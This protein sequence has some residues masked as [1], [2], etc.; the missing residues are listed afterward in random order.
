LSFDLAARSRDATEFTE[1]CY[2]EWIDW[3]FARP[4]SKIKPVP[5]DKPRRA[6]YYS[7]SSLE[8]IPV[9]LALI[10]F[11]KSNSN[12]SIIAGANFGRD[13]DTI[14]SI[15]GCLVGALNGA[16]SLRADWITMCEG[17]NADLF[18]EL[19]GDARANFYSMAT[20]L[21]DALRAEKE[22]AQARA[23]QLQKILE[24]K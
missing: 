16:S 2:V 10:Q 6:M 8:M 14:A 1:K 21:L 24:S 5:E 19:E 20:R 4:P 13:C 15:I 18:E 12:E 23:A 17:V 3:K 9:S 7:G 11:C 22:S